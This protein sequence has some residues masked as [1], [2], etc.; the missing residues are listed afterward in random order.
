MSIIQ[1]FYDNMASSYDKLFLDWEATTRE[2]AALLDGLFTAQGYGKSARVLDCA[3]GIGTQAIGIA[4]LGY[5]VTASDISEGELKEARARAAKN[6][7]EIHFAQA[8]FTAL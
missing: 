2:Q 6:N 5:G 7:V 3:C 1:T 4:R 8:D